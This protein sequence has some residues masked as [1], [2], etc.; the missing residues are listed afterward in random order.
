VLDQV[1][2]TM[3]KI[4]TLVLILVGG[5]SYCTSLGTLADRRQQAGMGIFLK[6]HIMEKMVRPWVV[7]AH[8]VLGKAFPVLGWTRKPSA[9]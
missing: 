6:L 2:G 3:A 7:R 8:G 5:C 1:H 4:I 9:R